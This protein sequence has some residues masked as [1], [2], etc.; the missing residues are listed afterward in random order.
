M[1]P[2]LDT[3]PAPPPVATDPDLQVGVEDLARW[4]RRLTVSIGPERVRRER[5]RFVR[6]YG[7]SVRVPGFRPGRAP[8]EVVRKRFGSKIEEDLVRHLLREGLHQALDGRGLDPIS[9]PEVHELDLDESDRFRVVAELDVRP[10]PA[11]ARLS[12]FRIEVEEKPL[13]PDAVERVLER[14]GEERA[15]VQPV[16]RPAARGDSVLVDVE[17]ADGGSGGTEG[18]EV[19]PGSGRS[20]A[21]LEGVIEGTRAGEEREVQAGDRRWRVRV[22]EVRERILPELDDRFATE[23]S[24]SPT[25]SHLRERVAENLRAEAA[26]QAHGEARDRLLD[27]IGDA[28]RVEVPESMVARYVDRL[29]GRGETA[30]GLDPAPQHA[31]VHPAPRVQAA[32]HAHPGHAGP[33][34]HDDPGLAH[35]PEPGAENDGRASREAE[36]TRMLRPAAERTLRRLLIVEALA[37]REGLDPTEEQLQDYLRERAD[38]DHPYEETRRSLEQAGRMDELRAHLRTE[39]VFRFLE[40]QSSPG[41]A[42]GS[43]REPAS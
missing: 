26:A 13:A 12:G 42:A 20:P 3:L 30:R 33:V 29:L 9:A 19:I 10:E 39:N 11:L 36:I 8:G 28:N 2:E 23:V 34:E 41:T 43:H 4:R 27:A 1:A 5:E 24:S 15:R 37:R 22:R 17:A 16:E 7:R 38:P 14:L 32:S 31:H 18:H 40:S 35:D 25:L 21:E 6:E